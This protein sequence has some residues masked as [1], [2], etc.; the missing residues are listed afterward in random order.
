MGL[1]Y[2]AVEVTHYGKCFIRI[3]LMQCLAMY[4]VYGFVAAVRVNSCLK[5]INIGINVLNRIPVW[6][7]TA[8]SIFMQIKKSAVFQIF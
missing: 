4:Y 6:Q 5:F 7:I 1:C 8:L 2:T 3:M